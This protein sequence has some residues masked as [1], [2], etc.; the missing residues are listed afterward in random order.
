[1]R[2]TG[3]ESM[4]LKDKVDDS[5]KVICERDR[6]RYENLLALFRLRLDSTSP[7]FSLTSFSSLLKL[8]V[9]VG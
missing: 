4:L 9:L 6:E 1:M 3:N 2:S 7:H 8:A 5:V